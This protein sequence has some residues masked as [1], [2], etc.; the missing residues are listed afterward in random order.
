M[1]YK[2]GVVTFNNQSFPQGSTQAFNNHR[3]K[4]FAT[5][6]VYG[7]LSGGVNSVDVYYELKEKG[8]IDIEDMDVMFG[9]GNRAANSYLSIYYSGYEKEFCFFD[10]LLNNARPII[11]LSFEQSFAQTIPPTNRQSNV[12]RRTDYH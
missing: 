12:L 1:I 10:F 6:S 2:Y 9:S 5:I 4:D 8:T 3:S 11:G 7:Q